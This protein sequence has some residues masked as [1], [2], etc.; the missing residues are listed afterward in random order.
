MAL[1][2]KEINE[3]HRKSGWW[4]S[5]NPTGELIFTRGYNKAT[6]LTL[7][8][9]RKADIY[10]LSFG[11]RPIAFLDEEVRSLGTYHPVLFFGMISNALNLGLKTRR[12]KFKPNYRMFSGNH[13][14]ITGLSKT[15]LR[16]G[17]RTFQ[18]KD[19]IAIRKLMIERY[20]E[21]RLIGSK[22]W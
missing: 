4:T 13:W 3:L 12:Y 20:G 8:L 6:R 14:K 15:T 5:C 19:L 7:E 22:P 21:E 2:Y 11:F 18:R 17:C 16:I 1:I 9:F 10:Y